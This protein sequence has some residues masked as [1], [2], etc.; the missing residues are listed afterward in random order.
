VIF[1]NIIYDI[2]T[3]SLRLIGFSSNET[4]ELNDIKFYITKDMAAAPYCRLIDS[5]NNENIIKLSKIKETDKNYDIFTVS[6]ENIITNEAGLSSLSLF[7]F[8]E[9]VC[10][11]SEKI[12]IILDY[13]LF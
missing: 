6:I 3:K 4:Y 8:D 7:F 10:L 1:I 2:Q 9:D 5:Y 11:F 12:S 13:D